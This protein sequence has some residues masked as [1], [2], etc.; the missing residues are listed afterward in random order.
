VEDSLEEAKVHQGME[1]E[2]EEEEEEVVVVVVVVSVVHYFRVLKI[3]VLS[4]LRK[5]H[6]VGSENCNKT[7]TF[8]LY[9]PPTGPG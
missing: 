7:E 4:I 1:E 8:S 6:T 9:R 2:E 5:F 3:H